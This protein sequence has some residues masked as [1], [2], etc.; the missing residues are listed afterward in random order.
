M[1]E[2]V[3]NSLFEIA[4]LVEIYFKLYRRLHAIMTQLK[5]KK[6]FTNKGGKTYTDSRLITAKEKKDL[7]S[8]V[9]NN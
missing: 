1:I 8:L 9:E 4:K 6:I 7:I 3:K 5:N 2:K